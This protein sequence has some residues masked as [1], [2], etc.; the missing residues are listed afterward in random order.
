MK[1]YSLLFP[2]LRGMSHMHGEPAFVKNPPK[3]VFVSKIEVR[4]SKKRC[5]D[6]VAHDKRCIQ[7]VSP[8]PIPFSTAVNIISVELDKMTDQRFNWYIV[9]GYGNISLTTH[10]LFLLSKLG[11]PPELQRLLLKYFSV[12]SLTVKYFLLNRKWD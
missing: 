1:K 12:N 2:C 4:P 5:R 11:L 7:F 3:D 10:L 6:V 8:V 9:R